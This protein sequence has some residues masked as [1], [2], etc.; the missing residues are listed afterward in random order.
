LTDVGLE[1]CKEIKAVRVT[2]WCRAGGGWLAG[3]AIS[4]IYKGGLFSC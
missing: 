4:L 1:K 2:A 3:R